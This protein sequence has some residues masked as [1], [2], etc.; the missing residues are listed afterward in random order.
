MFTPIHSLLGADLL[1]L[2]TSKHLELTGRPLGIS[3]ILSGSVLG[4]HDAWRWTFISGLVTSALVRTLTTI[5]IAQIGWGLHQYGLA[6]GLTGGTVARRVLAGVLVGFGSRVSDTALVVSTTLADE[7]SRNS[8]A[9]VGVRLH[10]VSLAISSQVPTTTAERFHVELADTF[11]VA[12][13]DY[14]PDRSS[15][16]SPFSCRRP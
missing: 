2:A 15:P 4:D 16:A 11:S 9:I 8:A 13:L 1:H 14:L 10:K 7:P 5:P 3:G 6:D 12:C